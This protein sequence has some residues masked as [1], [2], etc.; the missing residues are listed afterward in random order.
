T[1]ATTAI[2]EALPASQQGVGSALNDLTR[3]V[4]G[5]IGIAVIGSILT[6]T[7]SSRVDITGLST[8]LAAKV[9]G[10]FALP[11]HMPQPIANPANAALVSALH[12]A[13]LSAAGAAVLA[14]VAVS[15]LLARGAAKAGSRR[16]QT[17]FACA[18][19]VRRGAR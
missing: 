14:A 2:T 16:R 11:A 15:L 8:R 18:P 5:A 7:Y 13:L 17:V 3:E 12:I 1:P 19:P 10:S 4:G 6:S 9:K